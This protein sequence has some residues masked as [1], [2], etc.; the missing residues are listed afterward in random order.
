MA[1]MLFVTLSLGVTFWILILLKGGKEH[2]TRKQ[3]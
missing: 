3:L 2:R 1:V